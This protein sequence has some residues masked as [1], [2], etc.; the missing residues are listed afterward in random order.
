MLLHI[1]VSTILVYVDELLFCVSVNRQNLSFHLLQVS[2]SRLSLYVVW[3]NVIS[4]I[5]CYESITTGFYLYSFCTF[6][7]TH[8][9]RIVMYESIIS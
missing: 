7:T 6:V 5:E 2:E 8:V 9:H 4:V 1:F 3:L